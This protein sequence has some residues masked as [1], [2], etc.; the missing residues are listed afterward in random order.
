MIINLSNVISQKILVLKF[1]YF[2]F[3]T[4]INSQITPLIGN[5][6]LPDCFSYNIFDNED[7]GKKTCSPE[8]LDKAFEFYKNID[9]GPN[10]ETEITKIMF[11]KY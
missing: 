8:N 10:S 4:V 2:H 11:K 5:T 7:N 6:D 9:Q 1:E 3:E